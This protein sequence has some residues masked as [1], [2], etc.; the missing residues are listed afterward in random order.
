MAADG[1][2]ASVHYTGTLDDGS[3]FDSSRERESLSFTLGE[4]SLISG[5]EDA[6]RGMAIGDTVTVRIEPVDAY[7]E[8]SDDLIFEVPTA[9]APG[10]FSVGDRVQLAT[11]QPATIIAMTDKIITL[12]ANPS[13]AGQALTFAIELMTLV[14]AEN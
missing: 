8:R 4:G 7:G 9:A 2:T 6:V 12:D 11:G 3:E 10:G 1:D 5:F 13:L 14:K